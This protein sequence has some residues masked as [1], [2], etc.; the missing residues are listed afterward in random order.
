MLDHMVQRC[1]TLRAY[2]YVLFA[3]AT[4]V[5][6]VF[7]GYYSGTFDQAIHIPFLKKY[8]DPALYPND[9][10]FDM[11]FIHYSY[12]WFPFIWIYRLGVLEPTMFVVHVLVTYATFWALWELSRTLFHNPLA[13]FLTILAFT[14]PHAGFA[15][16]TLLEFS[17]LNRTF[18]LPFLLIALN[19]YL[20]ERRIPAFLM[21]GLLYNLHVVSVNFVLAMVLFDSVLR[22]RHGGWRNLVIGMPVFVVAALPVLIWRLTS[23]QPVRGVDW[24]WFLLLANSYFFHLFYLF[25]PFLP[26]V[27]VAL[28]GLATAGIFIVT[29]RATPAPV[30]NQRMTHFVLAALLVVL[31]QLV[32]SI[33]YPAL[34]I[35]QAQ[36]MR[37][38][39]FVMIFAYLSMAHFLAV[40]YQEGKLRGVDFGLLT[41]ALVFSPSPLILVVVA[42]IRRWLR[43]AA[44]SRGVQVVA[45]PVMFIALSTY[46][47]RID[48]WR[49]GVALSP[50]PSPWVD[51]Q[52]WA[53]DNTPLDA[54]FVT[55][56]HL[57]WFY[58]PEW[59]V[60]SER[61]TVVT[62]SELLEVAFDPSYVPR[63]RERFAALAPGAEERLRG[64]VFTNNQVTAEAFYSLSSDDLYRA[65]RR[66]GA[67]YLVVE[68]PHLH[69]FPV[70]YQNDAFVV[71]RLYPQPAGAAPSSR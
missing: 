62:L 27:F 67:S 40:R 54:V 57:W 17:L 52:T 38:G 59:R 63:W 60:I 56:P 55:P 58:D 39:V 21:L 4:T 25:G 44:L 8:A 51:V 47:Y 7:V 41:G 66:F 48:L 70:V 11:R 3:L 9:P 28:G 37:A 6:I 33:V 53:R 12:F 64:D 36:I 5:S 42:A 71:Y 13:S 32:A 20:R 61:S 35:V 2:R 29:R 45:L 10:F 15:G 30:Y 69:G 43:P 19:L 50:A 49:P 23:G 18:V 26:V 46:L 68:K 14:L 16:F 24:D 65:A 22:L 34:I 31:T 1:W